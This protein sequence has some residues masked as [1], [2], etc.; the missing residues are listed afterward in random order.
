[1]VFTQSREGVLSFCENA[2]NPKSLEPLLLTPRM[3]VLLHFPR[4]FSSQSL[5]F[6]SSQLLLFKSCSLFFSPS[7]DQI[8]VHLS[9]GEPAKT[10]QLQSCGEAHVESRAL[11]GRIA[12]WRRCRVAVEPSAAREK[13]RN[14]KL[15]IGDPLWRGL[16]NR[17]DSTVSEDWD[18]DIACPG[19][20]LGPHENN[21][22]PQFLF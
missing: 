6:A 1:M 4:V 12:A 5:L 10:R 19:R 8:H 16:P 14:L 22:S 18:V 2:W 3:F 20:S 15:V 21:R 7:S 11:C 17:K 13:L 9:A